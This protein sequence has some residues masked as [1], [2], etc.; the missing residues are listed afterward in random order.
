MNKPSIFNPCFSI[1]RLLAVSVLFLIGLQALAQQTVVKGVI[2]D[3]SGQPVI[4]AAV[5][6]KGTHNGNITDVDGKYSLTVSSPNVTLEISCLGMISTEV[7]I[8][9][10]NTVNVTLQQEST[11]LDGVVVTALGVK[12]D[13]KALG[14]AVSAV[15][16]EELTAGREENVM[17]AIIGKVAGV[18]ITTTTA[19]P[20][21]STRV[22]IRGNSQ[23]SGS[24][25]PLYVVDGIPVDNTT[26]GSEPGKWGGY[27]YGDVLSS[28]NPSD[29][30]SITVLKGPS[31]S[32]LYGSQ[33]SNGVVMITTK[34]AQK[35]KRLGVELSSSVSMVNVLTKFDDYQRVYGMGRNGDAPYDLTTATGVSQSAWGGK[36]DPNLQTYIY[37]GEMKDY[38]NKN[39]NVLSF[40]QT[41]VTYNN[42]VSLSHSSDKN[43]FRFSL[44]D[45]RGNDIVPNSTMSKTSLSLR[46]MQKFGKSIKIEASASYTMEKVNNRP[47]L[48]D[49]AN[50]IGNSIIGLAPNFDQAWLAANY[51]D[52][53]G[54]YYDWNG[55]SYRFNPYW[56]INEMQNKSSKNRLIGQA[57]FT[58]QIYKDLKFS[59]R[60]GL[61]TY[62]FSAMEYTP[63]STPR[64][65]TGAIATR[66][67]TMMQ[68]NLEA[69]LTYSKKIG[70]FDISAFAGGN[71]MNYS[72]T[73]TMSAEQ[74]MFQPMSSTSRGSR[75][76]RSSILSE[77]RK[78]AR[79]THRQASASTRPTTSM[80]PSETTCRLLSHRATVPTGIRQFP[81]VSSSP[82]CSTTEAGF[83]SP[84]SGHR[85]RWSEATPIRTGS[86][87]STVC[88]SSP[89]TAA[90]SELR[91]KRPQSR[92]TTSNRHR[93][94]RVK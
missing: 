65:V 94:I 32:A 9:G 20:T 13:E 60:G 53:N 10:R 36:L 29:I 92:T 83:R 54:N 23:L 82:T 67:T 50:N 12:R 7:A 14:Y 33:A 21:G 5:V 52:E 64:D 75:T 15:G 40:F 24:N 41:G 62:N 76:R 85:G 6:E 80:P 44:S 26:I 28:I 8:Q 2:T 25:L 91:P 73:S 3:D 69:M 37:N 11:A 70:R 74:T 66:S 1:R 88:A 46:A 39:N 35:N 30:E 68:S 4:G 18:D 71:I 55:N 51:K 45:M 16:A 89:S 61:D 42:S 58:W 81:A 34:S 31:A 57:K 84:S 78:S 93:P 79:S 22:L 87:F 59:L 47:A 63:I 72:K 43:S 90:R 48:G 86:T 27:D 77:E 17:S 19:G 49:A 38:G 56:V